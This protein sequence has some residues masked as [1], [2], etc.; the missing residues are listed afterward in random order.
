[1]EPVAAIAIGG[2]SVGDEAPTYVIAEIGSK[3]RRVLFRADA[4]ESIGT[5]HVVRCLALAAELERHGIEPWFATRRAI[6]DLSDLIAARGYQVI[7]LEAPAA[8]EAAEIRGSLPR[9]RRGRPFVALVMDHYALGEE[10]L[11][12][13]RPLATTRVVIDDL[14]DRRLPCDILVNAN[15]GVTT[16]DYA[17]LVAPATRLMVGTRFVL[18]REPFLVA[19]AAGRRPSSTVQNILV[20]MGGGDPFGATAK[21]VAAARSAV[22]EARI[23]V[24]LGALYPSEPEFGLG[25]GVHRAI[26][27]ETMARLMTEADI[28]VGAGGTTS[29]ERCALG[30]PSVIVRVAENQNANAMGLAAAGAAVDAGPAEH[31]NVDILASLIRGLASDVARRAEMSDRAW[32]LVDG[33]GVQRV[34][35]HVDGVRVRNATW[36]DARLLWVWANDPATRAASLHSEP[37]PY[38]EHEAWLRS[39]LADRSCLLLIGENGTGLI[40]QVRFD[41]RVDGVEVSIS[42]APEHR[43]AVG[44]L[45]LA[46]AIRRFSARSPQADLLARVKVD[47]GASRRV[48]EQAGFRL[49]GDNDGVLLYRSPASTRTAVALEVVGK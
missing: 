14:A 26:D 33:R 17:D 9:Q 5:G 6:G 39:R 20:S 47:N 40:G 22:P 28:V 25:V 15:L 12:A 34:A 2:R 27:A 44:G 10:W 43:G 32:E 48:F 1:M 23:V 29:W 37:I 45:L 46:S 42:V 41:A 8:D 49:V 24:V 11:K 13:V 7:R 36:S 3:P 21:A 16:A 18:L 38:P 19:R 4:S 31:L 30:R 35:N